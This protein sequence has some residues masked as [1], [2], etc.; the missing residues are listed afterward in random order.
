MISSSGRPIHFSAGANTSSSMDLLVCGVGGW[1]CEQEQ[2]EKLS[3]GCH[4]T[5]RR[6]LPHKQPQPLE[7]FFNRPRP[8]ETFNPPAQLRCWARQA[9]CHVART[10]LHPSPATVPGSLPTARMTR[11]VPAFDTPHIAAAARSSP[12]QSAC[13]CGRP[14]AVSQHPPSSRPSP[15]QSPNSLPAPP[16]HPLVWVQVLLARGAHVGVHAEQRRAREEQVVGGGQLAVKPDVDVDDG[17]AHQLVQ[18][19][20]AVGGRGRW[21]GAQLK[22][23]YLRGWPRSKAAC[24]GWMAHS[25]H[26]PRQPQQRGCQL[27]SPPCQATHRKKSIRPHGSGSSFFTM[28]TGMALTYRSAVMLSPLSRLYCL[29]VQGQRVGRARSMRSGDTGGGQGAQHG[30]QGMQRHS[31]SW[32]HTP[33]RC[34]RL[35]AHA[36]LTLPSSFSSM[37]LIPAFIRTSPPR[38][39]GRWGRRGRRRGGAV[40]SAGGGR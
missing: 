39:V 3:S 34:Q 18:P 2:A 9:A 23:H 1:G 37:S 38:A 26:L 25:S 8:R 22:A 31:L 14:P 20:G 40:P 15:K 27:P 29:W 30:Q 5:R 11:M 6:R 16:L 10:Q 28:S 33:G 24:T 21:C 19:P 12:Q 17:H 13:M 35:H 36:H 4:P 7:W 32:L